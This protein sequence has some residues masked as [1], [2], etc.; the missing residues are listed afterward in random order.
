MTEFAAKA[1]ER[2]TREHKAFKGNQYE[3][4]MKDEVRNAL[5]SFCRQNE[6]FA[7]AV[8]QGNG[9]AGCMKAVASGCGC[10]LSD[11]KAFARAVGYYFRG[12]TVRGQFEVVL[13]PNDAAAELPAENDREAELPK[14]ERKGI[15][16]DLADF[17]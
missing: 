8:E 10:S 13:E 3:E 2:L 1:V 17:L 12:A 6:E 14:T 4:A 7:Q 15:L 16:L 9:F 5:I 11:M